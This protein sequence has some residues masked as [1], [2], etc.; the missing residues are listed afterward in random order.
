MGKTYSGGIKIA[1]GFKRESAMPITDDIVVDTFDDLLALLYTYEGIVVY[2]G[3]EDSLYFLVDSDNTVSSNWV[4]VA[5][6]GDSTP[7]VVSFS[8]TD[9]ISVTHNMGRKVLAQLLVSD[10]VDLLQTIVPM[11]ITDNAIDISLNQ[12][13]TGVLIYY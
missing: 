5:T 12:T 1:T 10:G 4:K 2:V 11:V 9:T 6:V 3:D 13:K 7:N 8:N